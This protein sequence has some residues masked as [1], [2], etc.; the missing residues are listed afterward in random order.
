MQLLVTE[1]PSDFAATAAAFVMKHVESNPA[2]A[3]TMPTGST[4]V[5]MYEVLVREHADRNFSLEHATVFMLDE[6]LDLPAYPAR[7]FYE[8][9]R[10]HLGS[11]IFNESTSVKRITPSD[12]PHLAL[13]YDAAIDSAGG[14]DL[15]IIGVGRNGHVG[16]NE[17]GSRIWERTHVVSLTTE[18]LE[19]NFSSLPES[20]RPTQAVTIG[21]ADLLRARSVLMLVSGDK[22]MVAKMLANEQANDAVPATQLLAHDDLT[23]VMA[24]NLLR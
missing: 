14:I 12:D 19:A 10:Y 16:F 13:S 9:L 5:D 17:P 11:V 23:I 18:T 8:Y 15:A 21:L 6:Y 20:E 3:L 4:P 7:S 24:A 2:L 22:K 1:G